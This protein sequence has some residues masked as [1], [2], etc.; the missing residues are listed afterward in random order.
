MKERTEK[1]PATINTILILAENPIVIYVFSALPTK[2]EGFR[3]TDG[4]KR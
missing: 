2:R 1:T 3:N 4:K